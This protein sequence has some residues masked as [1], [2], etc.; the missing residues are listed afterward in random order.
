M[1][2]KF[3]IGVKK[4]LTRNFEIWYEKISV[5]ESSRFF[6]CWGGGL[7]KAALFALSMAL[8]LREAGQIEKF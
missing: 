2:H 1:Y 6:I 7:E 8:C 5:G 3:K 4:N